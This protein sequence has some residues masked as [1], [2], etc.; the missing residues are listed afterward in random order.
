M[1][2]VGLV[3]INYK[4]YA[5]KFLAECWA[6]LMSQT[7]PKELTNIYII[8]NAAT[9]ESL[10]YLKNNYGLA[11]IIGRPDGNYAAGNNAGILQAR[12]DGCEYF[13]IVNMDTAFEPSWLIELVKALESDPSIGIA[14]SKY[15]SKKRQ[16]RQL[17][18]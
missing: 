13:I 10:N 9:E 12:K 5:S 1:K 8:D 18:N 17:F 14:Q 2:K 15:Y 6:G 11:T 16:T 3:L 7:Y 4:D